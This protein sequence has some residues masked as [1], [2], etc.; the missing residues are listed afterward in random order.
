LFLGS[1][2]PSVQWLAAAASLVK[3]A[4]A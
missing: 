4:G 3:A 2:Q 1:N